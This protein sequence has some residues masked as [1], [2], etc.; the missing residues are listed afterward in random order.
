ME[1]Y[2]K[3]CRLVYETARCPGCGNRRGEPPRAD[4]ECF[5]TERERIW[6]D[7]LEDVLN[8]NGIRYICKSRYGA[9]MTVRLGTGFER[10]DFYVHYEDLKRAAKIVEDLFSEKPAGTGEDS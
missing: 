3:D 10:V 4:D 8:Q 1:L 9:W 7:M 5:L 6:S 2:C